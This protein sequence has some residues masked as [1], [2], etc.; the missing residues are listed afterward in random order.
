MPPRNSVTKA[1]RKYNY[2]KSET[3]RRIPMDRI[4]GMILDPNDAIGNPIQQKFE[5]YK[6]ER[7]AKGLNI[8][9]EID[10][11]IKS[12]DDGDPRYIGRQWYINKAKGYPDDYKPRK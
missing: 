5:D 1:Y 3:A 10:R 4:Y 2:V 11:M 12:D 6:K 9:G 7:M 8:T